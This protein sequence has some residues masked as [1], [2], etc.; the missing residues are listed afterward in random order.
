M[1]CC[2]LDSVFCSLFSWSSTFCC[3]VSLEV[4]PLLSQ[5]SVY[6]VDQEGMRLVSDFCYEVAFP[7]V[8]WCCLLGD[9]RGIH[10]IV[11]ESF[12]WGPGPTWTRKEGML[13]NAKCMRVCASSLWLY[14]MWCGC[15][16]DSDPA[17][18]NVNLKS[19]LEENRKV[20]TSRLD[21]VSHFTE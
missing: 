15:R 5:K 6:F 17:I 20:G 21:E 9:R 3:W 1:P 10:L 2:T 12:C 13:N 11:P 18:S 14:S 4:Q 16:M 7:V 8:L 19:K